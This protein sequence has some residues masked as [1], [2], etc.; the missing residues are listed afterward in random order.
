MATIANGV[1]VRPHVGAWYEVYDVAGRWIKRGEVGFHEVDGLLRETEVIK[2]KQG[3]DLYEDQIPGR[4][5]AA[6]LTLRK[7]HDENNSL[8]RWKAAV[9]ESTN[10]PDAQLRVDVI[11][12]MYDRR[13]VPGPNGARDRDA[14][15]VKQWRIQAAWVSRLEYSALTG[16]AN[17]LNVV[18]ANLEGYGPPVQ[19]FPALD[20][21]NLG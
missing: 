2:P 7:G 10:L 17:D 6:S 5:M 21:Q 19:V 9:E 8:E 18:T 13:G 3:N 12:A 20:T 15:L 14:R 1:P 11:V 4:T 16:L